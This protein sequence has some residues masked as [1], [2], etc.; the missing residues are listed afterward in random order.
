M[1]PRRCAMKIVHSAL[2]SLLLTLAATAAIAAPA[3]TAAPPPPEAAAK[4]F[5]ETASVVTVEVPVSVVKA[6]QPV[7]GL[8]ADDFELYDG[9]QRQRITGFDVVDL[10]AAPA[11]AA[12]SPAAPGPSPIA[13]ALPLAGRRHFLLLFDLSFSEPIAVARARRAARDLVHKYARPTDLVAVATYSL[14]GGP[15]ILL[16]F[17]SDRRQLDYAINTL[18]LPKLA[19]GRADALG[20]IA[21]PAAELEGEKPAGGAKGEALEEELG[22]LRALQAVAEREVAANDLDSMARALT[23][24]AKLLASVEGKKYVLYLSQGFDISLLRGTDDPAAR[25]ASHEQAANGQLWNVSSDQMFGKTKVQNEFDR[26][27]DTFR[28]AD[29]TIESFDIGGID[30]PAGADVRRGRPGAQNRN[31]DSLFLLAHDTGGELY[32]NS[33]DISAG[34]ARLVER[35]SLVYVLSFEPAVLPADG[36]YHRLRV[37]LKHGRGMQVTARPGYYAPVPYAQRSAV[38]RQLAAASLVLGASGG[39]IPISVLAAPI[40]V[41]GEKAYVPVLVEVDGKALL[42]GAK[43]ALKLDLFAYAM[44]EQGAA[45]DHFGQSVGLDLGKVR[46]ALAGGGI[47]YY[48]HLDL[49]PGRY[50][51]RVLV[52][53]GVT[54]EASLAAVPITVPAY[55]QGGG[56]LLPPL[57]PEV[58]NRWLVL[59]EGGGREKL[60]DVPFPF[61]N[62]ERPF[63]P[64]ARPAVAAGGKAAL[65]LM[66]RGLGAGDLTLSGRIFGPEGVQKGDLALDGR[67]GAAQ[68]LDHLLATFRPGKLAPGDY[69]LVVTLTDPATRRELT[70]SLPFAVVAAP[71]GE[72]SR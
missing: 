16:G 34:M 32:R 55:D 20:L 14:V 24:F 72:S 50:L 48:G 21:S 69:T 56:T 71:R 9:D 58:A 45:R 51:V 60:R 31:D 57:V 54:G 8:T 23:D 22:E 35:T 68:G 29:C 26:M 19:D 15:K 64:A 63:L 52:R 36:R 49:D 18:G 66:E 38:E 59:R 53:N 62:G 2:A 13:P 37:E 25:Q 10:A 27:L 6:G 41:A 3:A 17:S 67:A 65:L 33:N 30:A 5:G 42:D 39:R 4:G 28:R 47:K 70:S 1:N 44:D 46:G 40:P 61:M 43:D 12:P 7:R 11:S